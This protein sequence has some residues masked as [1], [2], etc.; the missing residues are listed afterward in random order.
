[1]PFIRVTDVKQKQV[2]DLNIAHIVGFTP[3]HRDLSGS[4]ITLIN[5]EIY[6]VE[7]TPRSLRGYI[8]KAEGTL[9]EPKDEHTQVIASDMPNLAFLKP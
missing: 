6:H 4:F 9:P 5:G 1:M 7:D 8:K 2:V 3:A